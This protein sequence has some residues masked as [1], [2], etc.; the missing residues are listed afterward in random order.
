MHIEGIANR[1]YPAVEALKKTID[2]STIEYLRDQDEA[3]EPIAN[4]VSIGETSFAENADGR[5][6]LR[7]EI[8][9]DYNELLFSNQVSDVSVNGPNRRIDVTDSRVGVPD[10]LFANPVGDEED[11]G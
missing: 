1:G 5:R 6:V 8:F 10:S 9:V 7:F 2:N 4:K 3:T 11:E